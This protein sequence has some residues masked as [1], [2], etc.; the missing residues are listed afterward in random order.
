M[1]QYLLCLQVSGQVDIVQYSGGNSLVVYQ[2]L[3][4]TT[5]CSPTTITN[6]QLGN[7]PCTSTPF[8][9][10]IFANLTTNGAVEVDASLCITGGPIIDFLVDDLGFSDTDLCFAQLDLKFFE[11]TLHHGFLLPRHC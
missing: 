4:Q 11:V 7:A 1:I 9:Y 2:G 8:A 6:N 5:Y 3:K 10:P